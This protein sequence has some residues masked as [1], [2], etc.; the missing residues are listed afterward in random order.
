MIPKLLKIIKN[1][2]FEGL[3][4][5][6][7]LFLLAVINVD[8]NS[9]FTI[10]PFKNLGFDF[11]PG[12]GLGKSIHY[13]LHLEIL[14]SFNAHPLGLFALAVLLHRIYILSSGALKKTVLTNI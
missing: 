6:S 3:F 2:P 12:C 14:K 4:W 5:I 8:S 11:C 1:I 10:C 9:H 7:A 13:L